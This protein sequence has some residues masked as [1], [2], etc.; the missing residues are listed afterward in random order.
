MYT[1]KL[2]LNWIWAVECAAVL[3]TSAA[4]T[5]AQRNADRSNTLPPTAVSGDKWAQW[6]TKAD[7]MPFSTFNERRP[8]QSTALGASLVLHSP[9][10]ASARRAA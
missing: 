8:V 1:P 2:G 10:T 5:K 3:K 6:K 4:P 9:F 7:H